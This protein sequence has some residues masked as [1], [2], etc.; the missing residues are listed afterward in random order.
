MR[1]SHE[2]FKEIFWIISLRNLSLRDHQI[3]ADDGFSSAPRHIKCSVE[4][5]HAVATV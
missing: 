1:D 5:G 2:K 4:I 3:T